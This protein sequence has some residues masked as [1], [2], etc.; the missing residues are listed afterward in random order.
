MR[1]ARSLRSASL[2]KAFRI[3]TLVGATAILGACNSQSGGTFSATGTGITAAGPV[4]HGGGYELANQRPYTIRGVTYVP[5]EDPNYS[6]TGL[7]SWY[8][9]DFHNQLTANGERYDMTALT[10]AHKTLP[11]PSYVRVTNLDNGSSIVV[12]VNDRGPFVDDRIID[13]SAQAANL[14]GFYDRGVANVRV[15]YVGRAPLQGDDTQMLMATYSPPGGASNTAIAYNEQT[16]TV[17]TT[18]A[19]GPLRRA[20][21]PFQNGAAA[22]VFE[23]TAVPAGQDPLAALTTVP[24]AQG[25]AEAPRLSPAQ[26]ALRD[27]ANAAPATTGN[28]MIQVGVFGDRTN[29]DRIAAALER[30]GTVS[31]TSLPGVERTLWSVRLSVPSG[32]AQAAVAAAV[33]AGA[34][35]AHVL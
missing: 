2:P 33:Q 18:A 1:I 21:N 24:T 30:H 32:G 8:G 9:S 31:I 26:Q 29:V 25:Y 13:M 19:T 3:A 34:S 12:R 27:I 20:F 4:P 14:L 10:A 17:S 15:D 16:R 35:G 23:P 28:V 6:R 5:T 11:L 7:A 22:A